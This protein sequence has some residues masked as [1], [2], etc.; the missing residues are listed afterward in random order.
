MSEHEPI[1]VA[2]E[3]DRGVEPLT[4]RINRGVRADR[5]DFV[6]WSGLAAALTLLL[7]E[8][9]AADASPTSSTEGAGS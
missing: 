4:G 8:G 1:R 5:R 3:I 9:D 6:G 7:D 2:L